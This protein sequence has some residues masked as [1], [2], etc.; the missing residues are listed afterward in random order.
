MNDTLI[1]VLLGL[2]M[3]AGLAG[4]LL[5]VLPDVVVIWSSALLYGLLIGW[6][7][8]G[9]WLFA[10]ISAMALIAFLADLWVSGWGARRGGASSWSSA[11]GLAAGIIGLL[12]A[13]PIGLIAGM[14]LGIFMIEYLRHRDPDRAARA[15]FG[16]GVGYGASFFVKFLLGLAMIA[17]W[18][19]W[20]MSV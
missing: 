16:L 2:G 8:S 10:V 14:L 11:G 7:K 18:I 9:T 12:I 19:V 15:M 5:P 20:V 3:L 4:M 17:L 1:T 13:G 6:G